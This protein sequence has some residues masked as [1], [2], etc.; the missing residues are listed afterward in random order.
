MTVVK[1]VPTMSPSHG[2]SL[3][4]AFMS[5]TVELPLTGEDTIV[6]DDAA[7]PDNGASFGSLTSELQ[8]EKVPK[9]CLVPKEYESTSTY[10]ASDGGPSE[11]QPCDSDNFGSRR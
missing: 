6:D 7:L 10:I 3:E 1:D 4:G 8:P 11:L 5:L 2:P 9:V